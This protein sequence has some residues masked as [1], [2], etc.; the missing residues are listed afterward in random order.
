MFGFCCH[1]IYFPHDWLHH[2][3]DKFSKELG[4]VGH[5]SNLSGDHHHIWRTFVCQEGT[6]GDSSDVS[7]W[8]IFSCHPCL[9]PLYHKINLS[10]HTKNEK[11][12][13]AKPRRV[14]GNPQRFC[15]KKKKKNRWWQFVYSTKVKVGEGKI[16]ESEYMGVSS[17]P[18]FSIKL[19]KRWLRSNKQHQHQLLPIEVLSKIS[20]LN[21]HFL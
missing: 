11:E 19:W 8:P 15:L 14:L 20:V 9:I 10:Y 1:T 7:A 2:L 4:V 5:E 17:W 21:T 18:V 12:D 16:I 3:H 13:L 6:T